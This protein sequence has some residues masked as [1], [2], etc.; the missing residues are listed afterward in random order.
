[1]FECIPNVSEGRDPAVIDTLARAAGSSLLD[2]H[3]DADHHRS[4]FTL[5]ATSTRE[6][7]ESAEA[8]ALVVADRLDV[9]THT[10]AHP[11]FGALDVVPFVAFDDSSSGDVT[12][13]VEAAIRFAAWVGDTLAIPSF[14]YGSADPEAR[15]LPDVRRDAFSRRTPDFGPPSPHPRLGATAI[16]ARGLLVAVNVELREGDLALARSIARSVRERDGGLPGV[17]ALGF[18]LVSRGSVQVSMNLVDLAATG[19]E[20][21]CEE[22]RHRAEDAGAHVE[23]VELV[24]LLPSAELA[25]TSTGFREWAR[26]GPDQTIEARL[27]ARGLAGGT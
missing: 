4:V 10:G 25:R 20:R 23:R 7:L 21:A 6:A 16:G 3:V 12:D 18:E 22:V 26:I 19:L 27:A 9:S 13:A 24:G 15:G 1:M 5:G 11:R 17:R 8:L 14:L 2:V